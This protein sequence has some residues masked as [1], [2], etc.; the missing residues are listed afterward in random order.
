M[1]ENAA[2]RINL[3]LNTNHS[4][5]KLVIIDK[6][7]DVFKQICSFL[8]SKFSVSK[9]KK[10]CL[11]T[12]NEPFTDFSTL[13]DDMLI[14]V[15]LDDEK[16]IENCTN[17]YR[18]RTVC[19][20]DIVA[21]KSSID[22]S[23]INQLQNIAK[24]E[25]MMKCVGM[26]DLHPGNQFPIGVACRSTKLY[27]QLVGQ[28]IG[29]GMSLFS[30]NHSWA[31]SNRDLERMVHVLQQTEF[32]GKR[33]KGFLHDDPMLLM[34][35]VSF[36]TIGAG[37]HFAEFQFVKEMLIP[38]YLDKDKLHLL[39]HSGSR[40]LG[41]AILK[42]F[43]ED[44]DRY[45]LYHDGCVE[46][47]RSNRAA[48]AETVAEACSVELTDQIVD[49]CHNNVVMERKK[50]EDGKIEEI[51]YLHR[52]GVAPTDK[53]LIAIP[54][55]RGTSTYLVLPTEDVGVHEKYNK[56]VAHGAGR[57]YSRKDIEERMRKRYGKKRD[58]DMVEMHVVYRDRSL[59][60]QEAPE[61]YKN[62]DD[63]IQ[64]LVDAGLVK[65]VAIL[66]PVLTCKI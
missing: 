61:A 18:M 7:D 33:Y 3:A 54:G 20:W 15:C 11:Y 39:I 35:D 30:T 32:K 37:N 29:C 43:M 13:C 17:A 59:I 36:G 40:T 28:D 41:E 8:Y 46:W 23:A 47:A 60:L 48:I 1:D 14:I 34:H 57:M 66:T 4:K 44:K 63:V 6:G 25:G 2:C 16:P 22:K 19:E 27:P 56:S 21:E 65:V 50:V 5:R 31:V 12:N 51:T 45:L 9:K 53:G 10:I 38:G 58:E 49:I 42:T 24:M 55:S 26:P 62:I 52:K 64:D